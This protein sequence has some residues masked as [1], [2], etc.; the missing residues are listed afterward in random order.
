MAQSDDNMKLFKTCPAVFQEVL[1]QF[2]V[3]YDICVYTSKEILVPD[4]L[5]KVDQCAVDF[6]HMSMQ[7]ASLADKS[8][9]WCKTCQ[10][11]FKNLEK[12]TMKSVK[13]MLKRISS[14]AKDLSVGFKTIGEWCRELA[15]RFHEA[16]QLA[17]KNTMVF[18]EK[19]DREKQEADKLTKE[20]TSKLEKLEI[21]AREKRSNANKWS[22]YASIPLIGL[23][24]N[25]TAAAKHLVAISA[26]ESVKCANTK[27][28][29]AKRV[30]LETKDKQ[31]KAK[32][33][34]N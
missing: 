16:E 15:G 31:E 17:S 26:E 30:L 1:I 25:E 11:F 20:L 3:C 22:G 34:Y 29:N 19:L 9:I 2:K 7:T 23:L 13:I 8:S 10:T 28:E 33:R 32:V 4:T 21:A 5:N 14:Q 24:F 6:R 27:S 18:Q 12:L